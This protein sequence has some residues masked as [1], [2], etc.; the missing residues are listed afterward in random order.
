MTIITDIQTVGLYKNRK[1]E[2][3]NKQERNKENIIRFY[4]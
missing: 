2:Q 3:G 4:T 1:T